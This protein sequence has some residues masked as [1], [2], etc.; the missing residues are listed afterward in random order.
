MFGITLKDK[1]YF[2]IAQK[3]GN[4]LFGTEEMQIKAI[5]DIFPIIKNDIEI[6]F[7]SKTF[8]DKTTPAEFLH[9]IISWYDQVNNNKWHI[10]ENNGKY[11]IREIHE[12]SDLAD[13]HSFS[14]DF[15]VYIDKI[16]PALSEGILTA[17]NRLQ[18]MDVTLWNSRYEEAALAMMEED[19]FL[20]EMYE[21]DREESLK[22]IEYYKNGDPAQFLERIH[23][24]RPT[25][26]ALSQLQAVNTHGLKSFEMFRDWAIDIIKYHRGPEETERL[27]HYTWVNEENSDMMIPEDYLRISWNTEDELYHS[28]CQ[29]IDSHANEYGLLPL[30]E[31]VEIGSKQPISAFPNE[32]CEFMDKGRNAVWKFWEEKKQDEKINELYREATGSITV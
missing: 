9:Q 19:G 18:F 14:A 25:N 8:S 31:A 4:P 24:I 17:I 26:Y 5:N 3:I 32:I 7:A 27:A 11:V 16:E 12:H 22:V 28:V 6:F 1:N 20:Q 23:E 13:F 21:E 30:S 29:D 10:K 15:L 2:D